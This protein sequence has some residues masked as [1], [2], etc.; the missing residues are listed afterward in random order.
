MTAGSYEV[1]VIARTPVPDLTAADEAALAAL[2]R[3]AWSIKRSLDTR[4]E[5][6]HAFVLP[7]LLQVSG[8]TLAARSVAWATRVREAE[9]ELAA[10]QAEIDER[11]FELYGI[12]EADR[13]SITEGFGGGSGADD[14]EGS[15]SAEAEDDDE[16]EAAADTATL[17]AELV[18]WA[19]GV[20]VGRFDV[21]LAT[22]EREAPAEPEPF[23]P[24][25]VCSAGMLTATM[26]CR[27]TGHQQAIR[28]RSRSTAS[29]SMTRVIRVT[30]WRRSVR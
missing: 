6:S 18:S 9:A 4:T 27:S 19:V 5:T 1:G 28:S 23:D 14:E 12:D 25:P 10:I 21:R 11:C 16:A 8:S 17:A 29:S 30:S 26:A 24:L 22:G 20:A 2:A 15:E 13:R 7:A 3:R